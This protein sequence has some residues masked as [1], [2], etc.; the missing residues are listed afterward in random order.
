MP[1]PPTQAI[2]L[3]PPLLPKPFGHVAPVVFIVLSW[4]RPAFIPQILQGIF[5]YDPAATV[6]LSENLPGSPVDLPAGLNRSGLIRLRQATPMRASLRHWIAMALPADICLMIDD[7]LVVSPS[8]I[9]RLIEAARRAP[10]RLHGLVG[11]RVYR[12][13]GGFAFFSGLGGIGVDVDVLSRV[14]AQS[15]AAVAR[16]HALFERLGIDHPNRLRYGIDIVMSLA[17]PERPRVHHFGPVREHPSSLM[18]GVALNRE[19]DFTAYRE[20]LIA[21]I[22]RL[23]RR[24]FPFGF[25]VRPTAPRADPWRS[26]RP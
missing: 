22:A 23:E 8:Q 26:V 14:Y 2:G 6:V 10:R 15:G 1:R 25:T 12:T 18:P 24:N 11:E 7:D 9:A 21:R 13:Q 19:P 16:T 5:D 17:Q 20:R 3:T 4:R